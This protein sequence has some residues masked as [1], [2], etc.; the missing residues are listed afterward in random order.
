MLYNR[1]ENQKDLDELNQF[2]K[3]ELFIDNNKLKAINIDDAILLLEKLYIIF[4]NALSRFIEYA[5]CKYGCSE[6]CNLIVTAT[7][8]EAELVRRYAKKM[9]IKKLEKFSVAIKNNAHNIP[10]YIQLM[11]N[12]DVERNYF[13]KSIKC[14][15]LSSDN[16]CL[17]YTV[18]PHACRKH[19]VFSE[20]LS[21]KPGKSELRY[22]GTLIEATRDIIYQLSANTY[23]LDS[24]LLIG[25][26][27]I[28][29]Q[30]PLPSW[31]LNGFDNIDMSK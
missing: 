22:E 17:I 30:K 18:R 29:F 9:D 16:S 25:R 3:D 21:C 13:R 20:P 15:F 2:A 4:D 28:P 1:T 5:S 10:N 31:F 11:G 24:V 23:G 27:P 14:P 19:I 8:I 26:N 6:C 7:P 12:F